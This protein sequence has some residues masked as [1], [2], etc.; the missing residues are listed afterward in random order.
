MSVGPSPVGGV[1]LTELVHSGNLQNPASLA[2]SGSTMWVGSYGTNQLTS[3]TIPNDVTNL[4]PLPSGHNVAGVAVDNSGQPWFSDPNATSIGYLPTGA[5]LPTEYNLG[6]TYG[7][8]IT[9]V[10]KGPDGNMYFGSSG[11]IM[12]A[13]TSSPGSISYVT[14]TGYNPKYAAVGPQSTLWFTSDGSVVRLQ[15]SGKTLSTA[16]AYTITSGADVFGGITEGADGNMYVADNTTD[17]IIRIN[18]DSTGTPTSLTTLSGFGGAIGGLAPGQSGDTSLWLTIPSGN[19][20][21]ALNFS[22]STL[23]GS[24]TPPSSSSSP[25]SLLT[26]GDDSI[27]WGEA[28]TGFLGTD[29]DGQN[30]ASV[31]IDQTN[32]HKPAGSGA[33]Y[34]G[35]Y[36][37]ATPQGGGSLTGITNNCAAYTYTTTYPFPS[38]VN[39]IGLTTTSS[40]SGSG[41][42]YIVVNSTYGSAEFAMPD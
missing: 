2:L 18:L 28:S 13:S 39:D 24:I 36:A 23:V 29:G 1:L 11:Y 5:S 35:G 10:V 41:T 31:Y 22:T 32:L 12:E 25:T 17:S 40:Y 42:C 7:T 30:F 8:N 27:W 16:M 9:G 19:V 33:G 20:I 15:F 34:S 4:Y 6:S 38:G 14:Y 26:T 3:V 21:Y 37:I